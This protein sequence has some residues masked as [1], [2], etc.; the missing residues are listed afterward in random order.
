MGNKDSKVKK[1]TSADDFDKYQKKT[2]AKKAEIGDK[3]IKISDLQAHI[4]S[5]PFAT[6]YQFIED[7]TMNDQY[8]ANYQIAQKE[9]NRPKNRYGNVLPPDESRVV[10]SEIP[11]VACSDYINASYIN[12]FKTVPNSEKA[13]IA[14]QGP[15]PETTPDFWRMVW[16]KKSS[17]ILMLTRVVESDV[18]KCHQYW[19]HKGEQ[20]MDVVYYTLHLR[21]IKEEPEV[22]TSEIEIVEKKTNQKMTVTHYHYIAWPD[23]GIPSN[24]DA[25]LDLTRRSDESNSTRGPLIVHCSAGIGRTGTFIVIHSIL[26]KMKHESKDFQAY[27]PMVNLVTTLIDLRKQRPGMIQTVEQYEFCYRA[28]N[29]YAKSLLKN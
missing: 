2:K 21:D 22:V 28:L 15:I 14:T 7:K 25:F 3:P 11:G 26:E 18:L 20:T 4:D 24:A 29:D 27:V 6:E 12:G 10:L 9:E 1:T 17:V 13:Y 23:H 19:P 5:N 8:T 16:E